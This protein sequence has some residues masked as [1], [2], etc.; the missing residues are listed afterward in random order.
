MRP[1]NDAG[2]ADVLNSIVTVTDLLSHDNHESA[3]PASSDILV[4]LV[5]AIARLKGV[6]VSNDH[7]VQSFLDDGGCE[8]LLR[9]LETAT[10]L[11]TSPVTSETEEG[12]DDIDVSRESSETFQLRKELLQLSFAAL[13]QVLALSDDAKIFFA[14]IDGYT[15]ILNTIRASDSLA[16]VS[17]RDCVFG[18]L[19]AAAINDFTHCHIFSSMRWHL[20]ADDLTQE[21]KLQRIALK[22]QVAFETADRLPNPECLSVV[23][24]LLAH[25]VDDQDLGIAVCNALQVIVNARRANQ[26]SFFASKA[27]GDLI[28]RV[29]LESST[30]ATESLSVEQDDILEDLV[31]SLSPL[32]LPMGLTATIVSNAVQRT[33]NPQE[34]SLLDVL[35]QFAIQSRLPPHFHF[36]MRPNG[37][38][39]LT[40]PALYGQFPSSSSGYTISCWFRIEK[41]DEEMHLTLFGAYD[42]SQKCFAMLYIEQDTHK[43]V[44]QT[45]LRSSVRFKLFEFNSGRWYHLALAHKRPRT[46]SSARA[47]LYVDGLL[48]DQVK[49]SYPSPPSSP[50]SP[51]Q[52]FFGT[53]PSFATPSQSPSLQWSLSQGHVWSDILP[54]DLLEIIYHLG[55]R[56]HGN[57]QDSLGQFQTYDASTALNIRLGSMG[58]AK[59]EKSVLMA[60]VRGKGGTWAPETKLLLS[61]SPLGLCNANAGEDEPKS[62]VLNCAVPRIA[63]AL[64]LT[65]CVGEMFGSPVVVVPQSF[66]DAIWCLG[67]CAIGL[68][69]VE[70]AGNPTE[71]LLSVRVLFECVRLNWRNSEDMERCHGYE[72]LAF[73]LKAKK[74]EF[75]TTDV[76]GV[77]GEFIGFDR[78]DPRESTVTN[79]LAFRYLCLDFGLWK[80]GNAE[81]QI[82]HLQMLLSLLEQ[83]RHRMFNL[84][85][86]NKMRT[87]RTFYE[88]RVDRS[89]YCEENVVCVALGDVF[90][91]AFALFCHDFKDDCQG[92]LFHGGG[93]GFG[94]VCD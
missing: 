18:N 21:E 46:T 62:G 55:P 10:H 75:I 80:R 87:I 82:A 5:E 1:A 47:F 72:I 15:Q 89:R 2:D 29:I 43:L 16:H 77:V 66:D 7:A 94:H 90:E 61:V 83:S 22:I 84:R 79:P 31:F 64:A 88:D 63:D 70:K 40:F 4:K 25:I 56:Y 52:A 71:L 73:L 78:E 53:P 68:R 86:L 11:E 49:C 50:K 81:T 34:A 76:L 6:L 59:A 60:A 69:M 51:V 28:R 58:G 35:Q 27:H 38:S 33:G 8:S 14:R 12:P 41:F 24:E 30:W 85:R 74:K 9:A 42:V 20:A 65:T 39:A 13:S 17:R 92:E 93:S 91:R 19:I 57:F 36:D 67:G 23:L 26:L 32:G 44:L 48:V 37:F 54:E 45:S 3:S